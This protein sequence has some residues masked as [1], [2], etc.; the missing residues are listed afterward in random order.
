MSTAQDQE[1]TQR[2]HILYAD[3]LSIDAE[4]DRHLADY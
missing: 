2:V 3:A 4:K 1:E